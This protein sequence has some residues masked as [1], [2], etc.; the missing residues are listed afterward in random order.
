MLQNNFMDIER[1]FNEKMIDDFAILDISKIEAYEGFYPHG[2]LP[3]SKSLIIFLKQIPDFIFTIN[4]KLKTNYLH[5]LIKEMDK[6]SYDFSFDL[7]NEGFNTVPVPCFFPIELKNGKLK[8]YLS[9][10]H[11]AEK[12]GMGSIGLNS[13]LISEKYG[14]RLCL[15]AIITEKY[16]EPKKDELKKPLC[17][18]CRRCINSCPSEAIKNGYV[19]TTKCINFSN[20]VPV[21]IRP[22]IKNFM[23]W[24]FSKKYIEI[25]INTLSWNAEMVCSEC[26]IN[27]PFFK[28]SNKSA[29]CT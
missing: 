27:C 24:N 12:A 26:L 20:L 10:K 22:F 14:N 28:I 5:L 19:E 8:G 13:L 21:I 3:N 17:H 23:K 25:M 16:F 9:L 2:L 11:F 15:S 29:T 18:N 4:A 1:Y 6:I 7:N